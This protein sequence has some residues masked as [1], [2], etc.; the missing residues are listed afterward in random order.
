MCGERGLQTVEKAGLS[1]WDIFCKLPA[2]SQASGAGAAGTETLFTSVILW[3]FTAT[4]Y[5]QGL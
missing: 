5:R 2:A 1:G 3:G 4:G